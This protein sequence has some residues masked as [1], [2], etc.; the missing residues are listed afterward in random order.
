MG[1]W[2]LDGLGLRV[3]GFR[4]WG[5]RDLV[6]SFQALGCFG[7]SVAISRGLTS[8]GCRG[9]GVVGMKAI[10]MQNFAVLRHLAV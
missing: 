1:G 7:G 8:S 4:V 2:G 9:L 5:L 6:K 10:V 3:E